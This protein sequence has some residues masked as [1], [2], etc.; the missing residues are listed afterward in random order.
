MQIEFIHAGKKL[1]GQSFEIP[2]L[3]QLDLILVQDGFLKKIYE[4]ST[5]MELAQSNAFTDQEA[6]VD[7]VGAFTKKNV[8]DNAI[9]EKI[10]SAQ[11]NFGNKSLHV[12]NHSPKYEAYKAEQIAEFENSPYAFQGEERARLQAMLDTAIAEDLQNIK[13]LQSY[14]ESRIYKKHIK[15]NLD[16]I[17]QAHERERNNKKARTFI[18][19][20]QKLPADLR[21]EYVNSPSDLASMKQEIMMMRK[22]D[23]VKYIPTEVMDL[24]YPLW[25]RVKEL[26]NE[27]GYVKYQAH[28]LTDI[29]RLG[30]LN[31]KGADT[32][33]LTVG[34]ITAINQT[35][36]EIGLS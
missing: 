10:Y 28:P 18:S 3:E 27:Y 9:L 12:I 16:F 21:G 1:I 2:S 7:I 22:R 26:N 36:K 31:K 17:K 35:A 11:H 23:I 15:A 29:I 25:R 24:F 19:N 8:S 34:I 13:I 14:L 20:G 33:T 4:L 6:I 32:T 30:I 5:G